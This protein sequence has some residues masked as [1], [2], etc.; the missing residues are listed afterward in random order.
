MSKEEAGEWADYYIGKNGEKGAEIFQDSCDDLLEFLARVD[1]W[2]R[3][4]PDTKVHLV[5][6]GD[7]LDFWIG[8]KLGFGG[9]VAPR[10][11]AEQFARFWFR[12]TLKTKG[13]GEVLKWFCW[14][15]GL[16]GIYGPSQ[17]VAEQ[18]GRAPRPANLEVTVLRGNHDNYM[19]LFAGEPQFP[20]YSRA[21]ADPCVVAEHGHQWDSFNQDDGARDGWA[22]TQAAFVFPEVRDWE[23]SLAVQLTRAKRG[24]LAGK[25]GFL[26]G[27][28]GSRLN[29][30]ARAAE[31]CK[32]GG[33]LIYVMGHTHQPLLRRV[34]IRY[35]LN[36]IEVVE[37][38]LGCTTAWAKR[39]ADAT[40]QFLKD[41]R[42]M[43]KGKPARTEDLAKEYAGRMKY[44]A[45]WRLAKGKA[46]LEKLAEFEFEKYRKEKMGEVLRKVKEAKGELPRLGNAPGAAERKKAE[47]IRLQIL[48]ALGVLEAL[49]HTNELRNE[50]A[51]R[52][53]D[54]VCNYVCADG[55]GDLLTVRRRLKAAGNDLER[56]DP[57]SQ[58]YAGDI[59]GTECGE[60]GSELQKRKE[61]AEK[62]RAELEDL[63]AT[64]GQRWYAPVSRKLVDKASEAAKRLKQVLMKIREAGR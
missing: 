24:Y 3:N 39:A 51:L 12:E 15:G 59:F 11:G 55:D 41:Y 53:A 60:L 14:Y 20:P 54:D 42:E 38:K 44:S 17:M 4:H 7:L 36:S 25:N 28:P 8:L 31:V 21:V 19:K 22:L 23:D 33:K 46:E 10:N 47:K 56:L 64:A 29:Y 48:E 49:I 16:P 27:D 52:P 32:E 40:E 1:E 61:S 34:N 57:V 6:T 58:A 13:S 35:Q 45:E 26:A 30:V 5:Q 2:A 62:A 50:D 63:L 43:L 9:D 37:G 18:A